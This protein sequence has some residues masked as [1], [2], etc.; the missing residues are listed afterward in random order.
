MERIEYSRARQGRLGHA[1]EWLWCSW[2]GHRWGIAYQQTE[3]ARIAQTGPDG[4]VLRPLEIPAVEW[5]THRCPRCDLIRAVGL[6][7]GDGAG[8]GAPAPRE[9]RKGVLGGTLFLFSPRK[10]AKRPSRNSRS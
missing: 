5:T 6:V 7:L 4:W 10:A 9:R 8:A 2:R 1:M 3:F